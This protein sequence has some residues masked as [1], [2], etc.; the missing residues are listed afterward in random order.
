MEALI[1]NKTNIST[2]PPVVPDP[3]DSKY[4]AQK[5]KLEAYNAKLALYN[6]AISATRR[7]PRRRGIS[8]L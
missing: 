7:L 5:A 2:A 4:E 3:S 8:S 6:T 1:A